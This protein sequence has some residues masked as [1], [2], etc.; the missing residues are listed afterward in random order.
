M[1][2]LVDI[3]CHVAHFAVVITRDPVLVVC[4]LRI[5]VGIG[6]ADLLEAEFESYLFD[7]YRG[8]QWLN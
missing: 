4:V 1:Q 8:R 5:Q 3:T 7:D 2:S 6:N